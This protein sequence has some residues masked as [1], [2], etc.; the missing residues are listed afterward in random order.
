MRLGKR[1]L[2]SLPKVIA[3][4]FLLLV[5]FL[6]LAYYMFGRALSGGGDDLYILIENIIAFILGC[7]LIAGF[8]WIIWL[9][10]HKIRHHSSTK[11]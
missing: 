4:E 9:S 8:F 7:A 6:I 1:F 5:V 2:Y 3:I 10:I 11:S